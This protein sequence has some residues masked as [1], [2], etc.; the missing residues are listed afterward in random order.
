MCK[1]PM[2]KAGQMETLGQVVTWEDTVKDHSLQWSSS[3]TFVRSFLSLPKIS[4]SVGTRISYF[5]YLYPKCVDRCTHT[6]E[7]PSILNPSVPET[8]R[9][10]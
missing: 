3:A 7:P 1:S 8:E 10:K 9:G 4:N 5:M 2:G 6:E